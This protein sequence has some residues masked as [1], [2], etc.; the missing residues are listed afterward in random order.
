[1]DELMRRGGYDRYGT[2]GG[3]WGA[4]ISAQLG[5]DFCDRC[6]AIHITQT[7]ARVPADPTGAELEWAERYGR[8]RARESAYAEVQR[9]K[10]DSLT[11]AQN[12][13]PAGLA[14]WIIE[15]FRTWGDTHGDIESG[16]SKDDLL[17]NLT[18]YW[19][20]QSAP[21]AARI[22]Y[23][24]RQDERAMAYPYVPVPTAVA[25]FPQEPFLVPRSIAEKRYN[26][27]RWTAMPAGGHF[28][29]L[30][31]PADVIAD[32]REFYRSIRETASHGT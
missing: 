23:E 16:F 21:T 10:P 31:R 7:V 4:I 20:T 1:M 2:H 25:A 5:A 13:S 19:V 11:V 17:T 8:F 24:M 15:K 29:A 9:T 22:Y 18:I 6:V 27:V 3:D 32:L 12:D 30:E 26:L 14:A 28:A